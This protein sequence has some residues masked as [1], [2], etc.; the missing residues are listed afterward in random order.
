MRELNLIPYEL[1]KK[2]DKEI[3]IYKAAFYGIIAVFIIFIV[4]YIPKLVLNHYIAEKDQLKLTIDANNNIN[5]EQG[6]L[7]SEINSYKTY[8]EKIN[9]IEKVKV[10]ISDK[11]SGIQKLVPKD[12]TITTLNYNNKIIT[13][14]G[15]TNNYNS[16]S[17]FAANLQLSDN[18]K[19]SRINSITS[20]GGEG[21]ILSYEF[22]IV[23][24]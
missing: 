7:L 2:R 21:G 18:Y 10:L 11:I 16:I 1:K 13:I 9:S 23:I 20:S 19:N 12:L 6:N 4:L 15:T 14:N 17:E 8:T 22:T 3:S 24:N 5:K